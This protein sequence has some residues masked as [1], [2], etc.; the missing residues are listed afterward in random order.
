MM[1]LSASDRKVAATI[2]MSAVEQWRRQSTRDLNPQSRRTYKRNSVAQ[3]EDVS[4]IG[5][6]IIIGVVDQCLIWRR[7]RRG[8]PAVLPGAACRVLMRRRNTLRT[9]GIN[10]GKRHET[11]VRDHRGCCCRRCRPAGKARP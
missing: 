3:S 10:E 7:R 8:D 5:R 2:A 6:E 11:L 9:R 1:R 4:K